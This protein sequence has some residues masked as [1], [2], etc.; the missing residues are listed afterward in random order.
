MEYTILGKKR[1]ELSVDD[2]VKLD[3]CACKIVRTEWQSNG[4]IG[5]GDNWQV[6]VCQELADDFA[7]LKPNG[8]EKHILVGFSEFGNDKFDVVQRM[9]KK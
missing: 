6:N 1:N 5:Y 3:D 8:K 7:T 9:D 2:I 4:G